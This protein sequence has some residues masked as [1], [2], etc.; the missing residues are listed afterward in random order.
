[1]LLL[2]VVVTSSCA[3]LEDAGPT[4]EEHRKEAAVLLEKV[5]VDARFDSYE[6]DDQQAR[7][8]DRELIDASAH[9][10][11][12]K[13]LESFEDNACVGVSTAERSSCPLFASSVRRVEWAKDGFRLTFKQPSEAARTFPRLRCHLAY[14]ISN[15]FDRPS[16]PLF[17]PGTSLRR[18]GDEGI[19]FAGDSAAVASALR[20]QARRVFP[21]SQVTQHASPWHIESSVHASEQ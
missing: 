15:G 19:T 21:T 4:V 7:V 3:H 9:L 10:T 14:A 12:A 13:S 6:L 8:A 20:V 11:A 16:C 17:I 18:E 5:Q 1:M 2:G